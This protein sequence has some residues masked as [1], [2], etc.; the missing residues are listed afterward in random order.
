MLDSAPWDYGPV[1]GLQGRCANTKTSYGAN[2]TIERRSLM[3]RGLQ[4]AVVLPLFRATA[5]TAANQATPAAP[6]DLYADGYFLY[7]GQLV[8]ARKEF[9][10]VRGA[11]TESIADF[12]F[13]IVNLVVAVFAS[14]QQ[15]HAGFAGLPGFNDWIASAPSLSLKQRIAVS[16]P[17]LGTDRR[18]ELLEMNGHWGD[19][20][21]YYTLFHVVEGTTLHFWEQVGTHDYSNELFELADHEMR[22]LER[23]PRN[24]EEVYGL[25][26]DWTAVPE[27]EREQYREIVWH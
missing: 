3:R 5:P 9:F 12:G 23:Q 15:A 18:A 26:P 14:E 4:M 25:L 27:V 22:F 13:V 21:L 19:Q 20:S 2:V 16:A 24:E 17:E 8:R 1:V 11:E 6:P 7:D 10:S